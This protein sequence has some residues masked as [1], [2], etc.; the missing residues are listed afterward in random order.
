MKKILKIIKNKLGFS[1]RQNKKTRNRKSKDED[2]EI[3][4]FLREQQQKTNKWAP[5]G[6]ISTHLDP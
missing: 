1:T 4:S 6:H 2:L 3:P 5:S